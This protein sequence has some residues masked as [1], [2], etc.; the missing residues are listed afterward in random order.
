M[1]KFPTDILLTCTDAAGSR[2][3]PGAGHAVYTAEFGFL[4]VILALA[5]TPARAAALTRGQIRAALKRAGRARH[6]EQ[7]VER[8]RQIFRAEHMRLPNLVEQAM[9]RQLT[10]LLGQLEATCAAEQNLATAV[11]EAFAQHPDAETLHQHGIVSP[12]RG[13]Q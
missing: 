13:F 8:L 10:A 1:K 5:S 12:S 9:G 11:E 2:A 6:V 4:A 7:D 3:A